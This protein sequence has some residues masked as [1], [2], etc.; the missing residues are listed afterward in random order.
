MLVHD[1]YGSHYNEEIVRKAID[2][3]IVLVL[4]PTNT[5]HL[6]Q[7]LKVLVLTPVKT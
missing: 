1:G 5:T 7:P 4:L 6:M 2:L 3:K